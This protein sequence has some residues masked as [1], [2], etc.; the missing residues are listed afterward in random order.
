MI[1]QTIL[2]TIAVIAGLAPA[3]AEGLVIGSRYEPVTDPRT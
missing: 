1:R 2:A 3:W